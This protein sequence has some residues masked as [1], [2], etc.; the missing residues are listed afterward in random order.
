MGFDP[1]I[2]LRLSPLIVNLLHLACKEYTRNVMD[3][4]FLDYLILEEEW[5][6]EKER[7]EKD[8]TK[9]QWVA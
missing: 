5:I 8:G 3:G 7:K 9:S 1:A 2:S 6:G 4:F